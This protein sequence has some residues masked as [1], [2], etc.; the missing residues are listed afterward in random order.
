MTFNQIVWKMAKV[1]YKKYLFYFLCNSFAIMFFFMFST[2]Y[3]NERIEQAKKLEGLQGALMIPAVALVVFT[4][5]FIGYSHN[6]FMK[7]R[8]SEFGLFMTLGMTKRDIAKVLLLENGVIALLSIFS[9]ILGG[10][11]F[12]RLFFLILMNSVGLQE[13]PFHIS[14]KMLLYTLI[15]FLAVF[16]TAVGYSLFRTLHRNVIQTLKSNK[17]AETIKMKSPVLGGFGFVV[18]I[19]SL[20]FFYFTFSQATDGLVLLWTGT[21]LGGLYLSLYQFTSFFIELAKRNKPFYY[22]RLLFL[23]SLD[24]RFK[25]LTSVL[26]LVTV[27]IMVTLFFTTVLLAFYQ[28]AKKEAL[29]RNPYDIAFIQTETKNNIPMEEVYSLLDRKENRV[30]KHLEIPVYTYYKKTKWDWQYQYVFMPVDHFNQLTSDQKTVGPREYLYFMNENPDYGESNSDYEE[31]ISLTSG[32]KQISYSLKETIIRNEMNSNLGLNDILVVSNAEWEYLLNNVKGF[33]STIHLINVENW[34]S[35][36]DAVEELGKRFTSY[37]QSTPPITDVRTEHISEEELFQIISKV[38][39]Y[40]SSKNV[41]GIL[42][43]V[44]TFISIIFFFGSFILL[45]L[46]IFADIEQEK[47]KFKK[48]YKIG[49]T[50]KEVKRM[51]TQE[52]MMLFFLPA[53]LGSTLAFLFIVIMTTDSGGIMKNL[54][55]ALHFFII[56]AIYLC[57]Q[58]GYLLYARKKMVQHLTE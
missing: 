32:T 21:L 23:T 22:R 47:G 42:F 26:M 6:I 44:M 29:E 55:I 53:I 51:I 13:I 27:M 48:I 3:F 4:I 15:A 40:H 8:G 50:L 30:Q 41:N 16:S 10:A 46:H 11:V 58:T 7:R 17:V 45:Y 33:E 9:G 20:L 28:S 54:D 5:F 19:G 2:V 14:G 49:I 24:Y 43:F 18:M 37:N 38:E 25:Q 31:G 36:M 34:E 35:S 56:A 1:Q 39:D 52:L 12:S 57:I